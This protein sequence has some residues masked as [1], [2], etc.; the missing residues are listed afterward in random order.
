MRL[1]ILG[2]TTEASALARAVATNARIAATLSLAG[3]TARP[4]TAPVAVRV[5][6]FGG[7]AGL[8]GYLR[9]AGIDAMVDATHPFA[10]RV[11]RN[12][13]AA[14]HE[15]RVPLLRIA[16]PAWQ[17]VAGDQWREAAD[18]AHAAALLGHVPQRVFLTVGQQDLAPFQMAPWHHYV[19]RSVEPPPPASLPPDA[20]T[21]QARGPFGL[22][23][24]LALLRLHRIEVLVSKNSGGTATTAKLAA[25]RAMGLPV[26]M[27]ARPPDPPTQPG[28]TVA[29]AAAAMAWV[30][31][32]LPPFL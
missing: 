6:G 10:A 3:R 14:A 26:V 20:V 25:A 32:L 19:V 21:I 29:D 8:A 30:T 27:V 18:M 22:T 16:R 17:A 1:L 13:I 31:G 15:A 28:Q 9:E 7:A 2:G 12:A 11:S 24:E 23:E 5:G 4:A